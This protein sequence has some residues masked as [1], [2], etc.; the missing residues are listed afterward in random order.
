MYAS[1]LLYLPLWVPSSRSPPPK[2]RC[3][4]LVSGK[5]AF[6]QQDDPLAFLRLSAQQNFRPFCSRDLE[7]VGL[8]RTKRM[9][10]K[11]HA[12]ARDCQSLALRCTRIQKISPC[13]GLPCAGGA[14]ECAGDAGW[15]WQ[16][17]LLISWNMLPRLALHQTICAVQLLAS[18]TCRGM[19]I[20]SRNQELPF[21]GTWCISHLSETAHVTM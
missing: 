17:P 1:T 20:P 9:V 5:R 7:S 19:V 16:A 12:A 8:T 18:P 10:A 4:V 13:M 3:D 15:D 2:P 6:I 11:S 14:C 21:K